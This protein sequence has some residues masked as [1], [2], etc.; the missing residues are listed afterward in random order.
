MRREYIDTITDQ[1]R[2]EDIFGKYG[3][4][5]NKA[6]FICCPLHGERTPSL[7]P[8]QDGKKWKCFGCGEG[9]SVIDFVIKLYNLGLQE[10]ITKIN[11]DFALGLPLG[12]RL[13]VRQQQ[14][15]RQKERERKKRQEAERMAAEEK[16]RHYWK[17]WDEWIRLDQNRIK[18]APKTEDEEWHPLYAEALMKLPYQNYL[19]DCLE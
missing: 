11:Y 19:I 5:P 15:I 13:S 18:Y 7:K 6:G 17:V 12:Q 2:M 14:K 4:K 1:I 3:Y 10:A 16:E 8:Y 9:G